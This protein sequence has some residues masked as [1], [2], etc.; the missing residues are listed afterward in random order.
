VPISRTFFATHSEFVSLLLT[1]IT[2]AVGFVA[3]PLGALVLGRYADRAGRRRALSLT[4]ILMA[5]GTFVLAVC[6]SYG[7]IGI[8]APLIVAAGR[9]LQGFS[10]GGEVG[11]SVAML[12]E[13]A[14]ESK[15]GFASSFQQMS[16]GGGAMLAGLVGLM[17]THLFTDA[18]I[19]AGAWRLAFVAGMLIGPVGWYVRR[20][21]PETA[22]FTRAAQHERQ[23]KTPLWPQLVE[24]RWQL[25]SGIAILVFWTIATYVSNYFTTYA[26]REL[27]LS[28]F[29]S[30]VGQ[31][32]YGVTMVIACPLIGMLSD[33]IGV[34]A[35]MLF[36]A[37]VTAASAYPLFSVLSRHPDRTTLMLVQ[38]AIALLLACY[39]ACASRVLASHF[40]V[41]FRATGVG[42]S[43]AI[44]VTIFGGLTPLAVTSLIG[45]TGDKLIVGWYLTAAALISCVPVLLASRTHAASASSATSAPSE[46]RTALTE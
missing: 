17:L 38:S 32:A 1:F 21:I 16:Q 18:Q 9:L 33:R 19:N 11:G 30:Y 29:D 12:V 40:P 10:A 7:T 35:P 31:L 46:T 45:F 20:S 25:L 36:G 22:A 4:L 15:R 14:P 42:F 3:R 43:Y 37:V 8:A 13:N 23:H 39:A 2:F 26:V 34:R 27:H 28:L 5:A 44:G 6:P 24:F 41:R